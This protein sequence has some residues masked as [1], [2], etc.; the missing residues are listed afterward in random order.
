VQTTLK[1]A[2]R[3]L[4]DPNMLAK[5]GTVALAAL[6]VSHD[7]KWLAYATAAAGSDWNEVRVRDIATG[8]DT[9]DFIRWIKF[10][11]LSWTRDSKGFFYSRFPEPKPERAGRHLRGAFASSDLLPQAWHAAIGRRL[12]FEIRISRNGCRAPM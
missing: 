4:L 7:G 2:P 1:S 12:I 11:D 10:S 9:A 6:S 8:R 3:A 5:D